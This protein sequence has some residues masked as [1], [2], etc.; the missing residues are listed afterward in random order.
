MPPLA[1]QSLAP[2]MR[3]FESSDGRAYL[4]FQVSD[5]VAVTLGEPMGQVDQIPALIAQFS[6][7]C[8]SSGLAVCWWHVTARWL[9]MLAASGQRVSQIGGFASLRLP[10]LQLQGRD[11]RHE[12][13]C[14]RRLPELGFSVQWHDLARDPQ[15]INPALEAVSSE[16]LARRGLPEMGYTIGTWEDS[17]RRADQ[18]RCAVLLDPAGRPAAFMTFAPLLD[19]SGGWALDLLRSRRALPRD[20]MLFLLLRAALDLRAEGAQRLTLGLAPLS[21]SADVLRAPSLTRRGE[22]ED[23]PLLLRAGRKLAWLRSRRLYDFRGLARFK[24]R[25]QPQWEPRFVVY[26]SLAS[27]PRVLRAL[28]HLHGLRARW[29][30]RLLAG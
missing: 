17:L 15:G 3:R 11:W 24:Q 30:L 20:A 23:T 7:F 5:G 8:R 19:S 4:A 18:L 6:E 1:W 22:G 25:L 2:G 29:L 10:E 13:N 26:P 27:L 14:L 28:C 16:W 9:G 12:R 21:R